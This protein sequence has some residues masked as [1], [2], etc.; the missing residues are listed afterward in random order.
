[1]QGMKGHDQKMFENVQI[2]LFKHIFRIRSDI[3]S[4]TINV[5]IK[6]KPKALAHCID[7]VIEIINKFS[8]NKELWKKL[9]LAKDKSKELGGHK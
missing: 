9:T 7:V 8:K 4:P 1:M 6:Y 3:E 5:V 2:N